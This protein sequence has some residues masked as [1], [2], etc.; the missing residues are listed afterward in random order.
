MKHI[1]HL[2]QSAA[3]FLTAGMLM[4]AMTGCSD[5]G[6]GEAKLI[7]FEEVSEDQPIATIHVKDYG[8]IR[9]ALYPEEA[10]KTVENFIGLAQEGYYD[11]V[12]FHRVIEDF[13]IQ[14]GD[15]TGTGAGGESL[16]GEEF[17]DEFSDNLYCFDGALCMANAGPDTNGSQF[18]IVQSPASIDAD[19][20]EQCIAYH[21]QQGRGRTEYAENVMEKYAEVGGTP[22]LDGMH[23]VFGQVIDGQDVVEAIA[24]CDVETGSDGAQSK[25]VEDVVIESISIENAD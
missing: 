3:A 5:S 9:I 11:G 1:K 4:L 18:F 12:T 20:F 25:P 10:P 22:H 7:Q 24:S 19:Y 16:W 13:M 15:P 2:K 8:D 17:E 14:G 23:T 21:E 6:S